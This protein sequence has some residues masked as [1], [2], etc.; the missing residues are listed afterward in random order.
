VP[1]AVAPATVQ[2]QVIHAAPT[3]P[4]P[5]DIYVGGSLAVDDLGYK[6]ATEY[7]GLSIT[8]TQEIEVAVAPGNSTGVEDAV[9]TATLEV[10]EGQSFVIIA[11]DDGVDENEGDVV[12]LIV[13][14]TEGPDTGSDQVEVISAHI[15]PEG[16]AVDVRISDTDFYLAQGLAYG[17]LS[18]G[19]TLDAAI[20]PFSVLPAGDDDEANTI[21]SEE[22]DFADNGGQRGV[23]IAG[24]LLNAGPG[25]PSRAIDLYF[26][27]PEGVVEACNPIST[28]TEEETVLP[29]AFN[30]NGAYPNPFNRQAQVSFDLPEAANVSLALYDMLGRQVLDVDEPMAAGS[31]RS[32]AIDGAALT[33]GVYVFQLRVESGETT[34]VET[35]RIT[36]V[37]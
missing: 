27:T 1:D 7:V 12:D 32:I 6:N 10:T 25:Q 29:T 2:V 19:T 17:E 28:D 36:V 35:G 8:G 33:S 31:S 4:S 26:V 14:M 30:L 13:E 11:A 34:H 9:L 24:G 18:E 3:A 23:L 21:L 37:H 15:I 22:C 5:V 16:P 20:F